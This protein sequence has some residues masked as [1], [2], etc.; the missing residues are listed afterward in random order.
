MY[1]RN[2]INELNWSSLAAGLVVVVIANDL[3]AVEMNKILLTSFT[4]LFNRL[5]T[6]TGFI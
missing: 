4:G 5:T 2:K 3:D 6:G 1:R